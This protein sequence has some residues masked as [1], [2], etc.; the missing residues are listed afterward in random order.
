MATIPPVT[1]V[2][3]A[4]TPASTTVTTQTPS[5]AMPPCPCNGFYCFLQAWASAGGNVILLT[6]LSLIFL[7]TVAWM[8]H[9]WGPDNP[10]VMFLVPI[11]GGFA[12][13]I[14]TRMGITQPSSS[15]TTV[16]T[17]DQH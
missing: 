10:A 17:P 16:H 12:V 3:P 5:P 6:F 15:S 9:A 4:S 11:A 2:T 14:T 7:F 1:P 8:M 13:A